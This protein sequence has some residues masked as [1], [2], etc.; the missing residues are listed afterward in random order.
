MA[1][2]TFITPEGETIVV[3]NAEGNLMEL[4]TYNDVEGIDASCGGVCSCGTCHVRVHKDWLEKVGPR[5]K[6]ERELLELEDE[7]DDRSRLSCQIEVT[8]EMDGLIVEVAPLQ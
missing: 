1:K 3:E 5:T 6:A 8:E 4:A 2:I 7:A